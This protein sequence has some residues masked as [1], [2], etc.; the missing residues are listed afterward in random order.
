LNPLLAAVVGPRVVLGSYFQRSLLLMLAEFN[1][2]LR[3]LHVDLFKIIRAA[4]QL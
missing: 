2:E 3:V 4:V 1:T